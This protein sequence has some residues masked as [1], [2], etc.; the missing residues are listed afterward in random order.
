MVATTANNLASFGAEVS[1]ANIFAAEPTTEGTGRQ[2]RLGAYCR[3]GTF[4]HPGSAVPLVRY[5]DA[6]FQASRPAFTPMSNEAHDGPQP[7]CQRDCRQHHSRA[8]RL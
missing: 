6:S 3:L 8:R 1:E 5:L 2:G 7:S 4:Q